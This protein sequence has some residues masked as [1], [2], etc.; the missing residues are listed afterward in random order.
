[1]Y[2]P[3]QLRFLL[4]DN[5]NDSL[6]ELNP[7]SHSPIIGWAFDGHPIYGPY[8]FEDA[9]NTNPYNSYKLMISSY[10]VKTS[11]DALLSGLADPMGTY[12]EDYEYIEGSGDLDQYNGRFCVTPE[13]P[14]GVYAYFATIKGSAGEPKFPYF[15]GPNFYSEADSVNWNGNGLQ[16]N[17]TEDAIRYKAPYLGTDN[18][19][20][21]RKKL[22]DKID[23]FLALEDTTTLI[24]METGEVLTYLEDGIGYFSYYPVIRGGT[25]DSMTVSATISIHLLVLTNIL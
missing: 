13:Y 24:V 19:V 21:K 14:N 10:S 20:A 1:M 3:K 7:T 25:A 5:I 22:D 12:I 9:E 11:R 15:V 23:F 4:R 8:A 16:K 2:N 17:F 6:Q 18:I